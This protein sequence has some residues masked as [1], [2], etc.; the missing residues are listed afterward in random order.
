[1]KCNK[2]SVILNICNLI[3]MHFSFLILKDSVENGNGNS[4]LSL[5][6]KKPKMLCE[7]KLKRNADI[8][9]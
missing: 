6:I 9:F 8:I 5:N 7:K 3:P 4:L 2:F 1:M